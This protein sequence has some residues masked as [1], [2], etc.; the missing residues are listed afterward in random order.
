MKIAKILS[1]AAAAAVAVSAVAVTASADFRPITGGAEY[2]LADGS[3]NYGICLF[4]DGTNK[5]GVPAMSVDIDLSQV[6]HVAFTFQVID[7]A[8]NRDWWDGMGGGAIVVS[9]HSDKTS[10]D[11]EL[12]N[13]YNWATA[14]QFWGVD[15]EDTL[16]FNTTDT[17]QS[18]QTV[19]V[20]DYQYKI[21]ADVINPVANGDIGNLS[22]YRVFMQAWSFTMSD[23]EVIETEL[24]DSNG[25]VLA[26]FDAMG[27]VT[28]GAASAPVV[29]ET[30]AETPAADDTASDAS[31]VVVTTPDKGSPDTGVEGIAAV[32]GLAVV[33]A[34]AV[35]L[36]KK[37]K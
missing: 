3:G 23:I 22:L 37:R 30:P 4:S 15:E 34:G 21:E 10:E 19:K 2:L 26:T 13:K 31:N 25:N 36:S 18:I 24:S 28:Y 33:A 11:P 35:V 32:A 5:D 1:V 27:N 16:G 9:A 20:G 29:D 7:D 17:A 8:D 12:Y 14:G 6:T